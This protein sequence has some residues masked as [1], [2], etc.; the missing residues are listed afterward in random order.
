[1]PLMSWFVDS[2][3]SKGQTGDSVEN[4]LTGEIFYVERTISEIHSTIFKSRNALAPQII[5]H[6][7][8]QRALKRLWPALTLIGIADKRPCV[9]L[10][11]YWLSTSRWRNLFAGR[12]CYYNLFICL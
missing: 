9:T 11:H 3:L 7:Y 5:W 1:M 10:L 6:V 4:A 12:P 8:R 2:S